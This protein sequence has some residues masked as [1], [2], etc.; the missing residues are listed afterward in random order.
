MLADNSEDE[1][2][3]SETDSS[4]STDSASDEDEAPQGKLITNINI[5]QHY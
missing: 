3:D 5:L 4:T 2:M 1:A